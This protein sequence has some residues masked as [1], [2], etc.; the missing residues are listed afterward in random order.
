MDWPYVADFGEEIEFEYFSP[1]PGLLLILFISTLGN[2]CKIQIF[3][4]IANV[5]TVTVRDIEIWERHAGLKRNTLYTE[6]D[7]DSYCFAKLN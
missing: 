2:L 6:S 5:M 1:L 7:Y 4:C 3:C